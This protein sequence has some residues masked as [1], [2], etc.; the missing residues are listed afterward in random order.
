[1]QHDRVPADEAALRCALGVL[2]DWQVL[3]QL[4]PVAGSLA[5]MSC[6]SELDDLV[7]VA[8]QPEDVRLALRADGVNAIAKEVL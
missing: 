8:M 7:R 4:A 2:F 3:S 5:A 6:A 1:M